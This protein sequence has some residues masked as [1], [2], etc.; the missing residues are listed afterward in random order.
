MIAML[1]GSSLSRDFEIQVVNTSKGALRWAVESQD[2]RSPLY[3]VRDLGRLIGALA[4]FQPRIVIVHAASGF[5]FTRDWAFMVVARLAGTRVVCHYH[6]TIHTRFPSVE[7]RLGRWM[8]RWMMRAAHRVI[9]LGPTYQR[10]MGAA[11]QRSDV[12]WSPN[13]VDVAPFQG[14]LPERPSWL[15][16]G[17]RGV[18]FVGRLSAPKGVD[19]L[20]DAIP[21]VIQRRPDARF[22]LV[23]VAENEAREPMLRADVERRGIAG[24][25][26]FLG[27]LEGADLVRAY[28]T[29]TVFVSPSWTEAFPLVIPE[30]M[31]AGLP[32]VV[33]AVGAIP[34]FVKD[35]EDGLLVPPRDPRALAGAIVRLLDDEALRTRIAA[36]LRERAAS[37]F[38]I[39]VGA[40]RVREVLESLPG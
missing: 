26:T 10:E 7:T 22:V 19:D 1:V 3:L 4:R 30:A 9:V 16:P 11:W 35:G 15:A 36:R 33:T 25:V 8:G 2:W 27:S 23:G 12:A 21:A 34:D 28:R 13:L 17:E 37:E 31:A 5:S 18:L 38:A 40:A 29:A 6:G 14:A 39:E 20:F 24:R 32:L